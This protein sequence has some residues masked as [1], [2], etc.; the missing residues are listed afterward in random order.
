VTESTA[1][2]AE[3]RV[4]PGPIYGAGRALKLG[5]LALV[6][7]YGFTVSL[8]HGDN[9]WDFGSF[10]ASGRA[11]AE[12]MDPYRVDPLSLT[13]L[14]GYTYTYTG[15]PNL[16]PPV[17][18]IAFEALSQLEPAAAF[19]AWYALAL[20]LY[21]AVLALLARDYRDRLSPPLLAWALSLGGLW[22]T[23]ALGQIYV[24]LL[25]ALAA[26]WLLLRRG[27]WLPAGLL[28]GVAVAV[29]PNLVVWPLLLLLAGC[30][31]AALPALLAAALL[32]AAPALVYGPGVYVSWL[33][34]LPSYG[35]FGVA[36]D[37]SLLG[38]TSRLGQPS[39]GLPLSGFLLLGLAG[40]VWRHRPP[41]LHTS[42]LAIAASLLASPLTWTGYT[43]F[44][45][46]VFFEQRWTLP[47]KVAAVLLVFPANLVWQWSLP[48]RWQLA[49]LGSIYSVALML[50]LAALV[51]G[52]RGRQ[53]QE[54][55]GDRQ[56][57]VSGAEHEHTGW[58][59]ARQVWQKGR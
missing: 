37:A 55:D 4:T 19:R 56:H 35:G 58:G 13:R 57:E 48:S 9:L 23:L 47:L 45:L 15:T 14:F 11:A 39:L 2:S 42:S 8:P 25:L 34:A 28:I 17:S 24:P 33:S 3:Q 5:A 51:A 59:L 46:P 1:P 43:L 54:R 30:W 29:K 49:A 36:T 50:V 40:V 12:G 53:G 26:A 44:L 7:G 32:S 27:R 21:L 16:N 38:L 41:A 6:A 18:L 22:S 10:V 31:A 20:A 52:L